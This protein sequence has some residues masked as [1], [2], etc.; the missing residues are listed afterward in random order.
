MGAGSAID[1]DAVAGVVLNDVGA[2]NRVVTA[3]NPNTGGSAV[4]DS[5][6]I[7]IVFD[8]IANDHRRRTAIDQDTGVTSADGQK[9][10][11]G[12]SS[13]PVDCD[14]RIGR[15]SNKSSASLPIQNYSRRG[16]GD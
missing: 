4:L 16:F 7:V 14:G 15:G 2:G 1:E 13:T 3:V 9:I 5:D 12:N 10:S 11:Y 6:S 8:G